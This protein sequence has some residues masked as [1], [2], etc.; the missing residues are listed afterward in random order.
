VVTL[1]SAI[2]LLKRRNW[3]RLIFITIM[4]LGIVV[5]IL[6]LLTQFFMFAFMPQTGD[7]Q[8]DTMITMMKGFSVL[9]SIGISALFG[10]IIWKLFSEPIKAEFIS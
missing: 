4:S 7:G 9:M 10:G 8:F 6:G 5:N 3:A 2:G 1:T